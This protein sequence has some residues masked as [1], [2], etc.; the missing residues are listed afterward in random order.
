MEF[1]VSNPPTQCD[2]QMVYDKLNEPIM[3]LRR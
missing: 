2:V 1:P 3:T